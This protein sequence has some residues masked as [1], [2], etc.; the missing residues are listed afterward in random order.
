MNTSPVPYYIDYLKKAFIFVGIG[1]VCWFVTSYI[2]DENILWVFIKA[3]ITFVISNAIVFVFYFR[4]E[5]FR[6]LLR[7]IKNLR[8]IMK[9]NEAD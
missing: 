6:Y 5:E 3:V 9:N 2:P 1:V 4:S 8:G 7:V